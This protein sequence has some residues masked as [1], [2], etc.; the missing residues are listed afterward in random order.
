[1]NADLRAAGAGRGGQFGLPWER[2]AG[3]YPGS[4][5]EAS[6]GASCRKSGWRPLKGGNEGAAAQGGSSGEVQVRAEALG[7]A[8]GS[9]GCS[10]GPPWSRLRDPVQ[11]RRWKGGCGHGFTLFPPFLYLQSESLLVFSH[12]PPLF[13]LHQILGEDT[14]F[15]TE[16]NVLPS[17]AVTFQ[18]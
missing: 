7:G 2:S 14:N 15:I 5:E 11:G 16:I 10:V 12:P 6:E 17:A 18:L 4:W 1:M 3:V 13:P 9:R 8:L